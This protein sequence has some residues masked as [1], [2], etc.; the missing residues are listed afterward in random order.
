[1]TTKQI[2]AIAITIV[3]V[4]G[5]ISVQPAYAGIDPISPSIFCAF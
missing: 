5:T 4:A 1:M 3:F 2:M